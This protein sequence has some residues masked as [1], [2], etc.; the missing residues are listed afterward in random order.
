[1]R[2]VVLYVDGGMIGPT[3]P[4][5][6]GILW[7]VGREHEDG[8]TEILERGESTSHYTNNEAEWIA[9]ISGL[10]WMIN[11][12]EAGDLLKLRSDSQVIIKQFTGEY[13]VNATDLL[14]LRR[15]AHTLRDALVR[16]GIEI[17][18][19]WVSRKEVVPRLGH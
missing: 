15:I 17:E 7:S 13:R 8:R 5:P 14:P 12:A 6:E 16:L 4:S 9:L 19:E 18:V 10:K 11:N 1:M 2:V 3:N